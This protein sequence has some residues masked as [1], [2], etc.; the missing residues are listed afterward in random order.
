MKETTIYTVVES[1]YYRYVTFARFATLEAAQCCALMMLVE[2]GYMETPEDIEE[3]KTDISHSDD[4]P[5][6]P[7]EIHRERVYIDAA[8][9]A[10]GML[11][12]VI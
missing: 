6:G 10:W 8:G 11:G 3:I 2:Q 5:I 9:V 12:E 1:D 7:F 4:D